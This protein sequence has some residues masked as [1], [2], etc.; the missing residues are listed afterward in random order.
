M[1]IIE[2]GTHLARGVELSFVVESTGTEA[3][4]VLFQ[5]EDGRRIAWKGWMTEK[6][7]ARTAESLA[8]CGY[9]GEHDESISLK[10]VQL[11]IEHEEYTTDQGEVRVSAKI[12]WVNDPQR[13]VSSGT[14][15]TP[16][17]ATVAKQRL[18]GLVLS[19]TKAKGSSGSGT[20]FPHGANAPAA[21][22]VKPK[23]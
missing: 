1:A 5:L 16:A 6:T 2:E 14:P 22:G 18:R 21:G 3:A 13:A 8:L 15:M 11:V 4:Q 9:D 7:T 19:A 12:R 23:F 20:S 10:Q 17:Q